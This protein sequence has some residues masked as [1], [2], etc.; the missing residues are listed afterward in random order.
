[1]NIRIFNIN[2]SENRANL[3]S[4]FMSKKDFLLFDKN[5]EYIDNFSPLELLK[6]LAENILAKYILLDIFKIRSKDG[7]LFFPAGKYYI[8]LMKNIPLI[9]HKLKEPY[10]MGFNNIY[11]FNNNLN[12][13]FI[14]PGMNN[15][16]LNNANINYNPNI[17]NLSNLYN[18]NI[19][20]LNILY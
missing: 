3:K 5:G 19:K 12:H 16:N 8:Y 2:N 4:A 18:S 14:F 6:Y 1:M 11:E 10:F 15:F 20:N 13:K 17:P 7:K 9:I